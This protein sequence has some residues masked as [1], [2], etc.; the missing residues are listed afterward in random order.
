MYV[1]LEVISERHV[2]RHLGT[3]YT[4]SVFSTIQIIRSRKYLKEK[5]FF[6]Y[7]FVYILQQSFGRLRYMGT[8]PGNPD[9]RGIGSIK[10]IN[11]C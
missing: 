3:L 5:D 4:L 11:Q 2:T 10:R 7:I 8:L 9:D 1:A 6:K